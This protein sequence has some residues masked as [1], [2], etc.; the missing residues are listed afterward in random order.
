MTSGELGLESIYWV[1]TWI[2]HRTCAHCYDDRFRP[3]SAIERDRMLAQSQA[4]LPSLIDNLPG[5]MRYLDGEQPQVGRIILAGGELLL[6]DVREQLLY[7]TLT[8]LR[9][10]YLDRGGVRLVIQ[11]TG[12]IVRAEHL[13]AL[14]Q[15][16]VWM[17]SVSGIDAH[18]QG[19][20][21]ED[22]RAALVERLTRLFE[23]QGY[24][25]F[26]R[27]VAPVTGGVPAGEAGPFYLFF[28][29]TPGSWIGKLWPRGRAWE[30]GLS[31]AT[32]E[33]NFCDAWSGGR[34]FLDVGRAGSEVAIDPSGEVFPCCL[35]T[36]A[37]IG[38]IARE[39]LT[40]I[41]ARLRGNPV[42]EAISAGRPERMGIAQGWSEAEFLARSRTQLPDG[43]TYENRCIGCDRFH[44]DVLAPQLVQLRR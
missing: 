41:L 24:V 20:E 19:Y 9:A 13:A 6:D 27:S 7:P 15:R 39:P 38:S 29:A 31:T 32:I 2:C 42:Y 35:K 5:S 44:E 11:T 37:P 28:G 30:G 12:D 16:G 34:G 33:D 4:A 10:R 26:E 22:K 21:R 14:R 43:R 40:Q 8:R 25:A 1:L 36:R 18:H 23:D 3:Y 17:V